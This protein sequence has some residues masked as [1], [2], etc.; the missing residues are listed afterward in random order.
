M[1]FLLISAWPRIN[2]PAAATA[3]GKVLLAALPDETLQAA[4]GEQLPVF[5]SNT[6]GMV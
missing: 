2:V 6:L 5:T 3:A 1:N 4:L